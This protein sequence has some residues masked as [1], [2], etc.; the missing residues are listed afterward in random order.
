M[1]LSQDRKLWTDKQFLDYSSCLF[2][3][4]VK[5]LV[6]ASS[7]IRAYPGESNEAIN[8]GY[9][10]QIETDKLMLYESGRIKI[11]DG[12]VTCDW[13]GIG[14]DINIRSFV[15]AINEFIMP[16]QSIKP[17]T[18]VIMDH[19]NL[20]HRYRLSCIPNHPCFE[21]FNYTAGTLQRLSAAEY[22]KAGNTSINYNWGGR[23]TVAGST[24]LVPSL[25]S[26]DEVIKLI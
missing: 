24:R 5:W 12:F 4:G 8:A 7:G 14:K 19:K 25:L 15:R 18:V 11:F 3:I 9:W 6:D 20:G 13:Q 22:Q 21:D 10:Q 23:R 26:L 2:E 16:N 17:Q 1:G